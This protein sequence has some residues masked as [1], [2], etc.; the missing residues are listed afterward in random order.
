[1]RDG[2]YIV[3]LSVERYGSEHQ[4][5]E[6]NTSIGTRLVPVSPTNPNRVNTPMF[7][8]YDDVTS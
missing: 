8:M 1:M 7:P 6:L 4:L 2:R 3:L 5:C